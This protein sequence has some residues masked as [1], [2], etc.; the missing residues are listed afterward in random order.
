M[1]LLFQQSA[2]KMIYVYIY[3]EMQPH[4]GCLVPFLTRHGTRRWCGLAGP[5]MKSSVRG[6][7]RIPLSDEPAY[8]V[9]AVHT[10]PW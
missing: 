4:R 10:G 3:L 8:E 6:P 5:G 1:S 7:L 2:G 9:A